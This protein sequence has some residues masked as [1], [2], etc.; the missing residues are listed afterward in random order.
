[1]PGLQSDVV[2]MRRRIW[3]RLRKNYFASHIAVARFIR[4]VP[5][6]R[7]NASTEVRR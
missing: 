3:R 5:E 4:A 6:D 1:M 2:S 7:T